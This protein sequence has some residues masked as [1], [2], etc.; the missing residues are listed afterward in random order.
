MHILETKNPTISQLIYMK[1]L[2]DKET[3]LQYMANKWEKNFNY[4]KVNHEQFY[5]ELDILEL[6]II[7]VFSLMEDYYLI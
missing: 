4:G 1:D 7:E 6:N 5:K 3:L 2:F